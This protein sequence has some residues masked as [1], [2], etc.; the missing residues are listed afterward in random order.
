MERNP[1]L[2]FSLLRLHLISLIQQSHQTNDILPALSFASTH[3]APRAHLDRSYLEELERTMA[4]LCFP[5]DQDV[6]GYLNEPNLK[7]SVAIRVNLALIK[8][9]FGAG[10][11]DSLED[12]EAKVRGL[13]RLW[14]WAEDKLSR[15]NIYAPV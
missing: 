15:I 12:Q 8:G 9:V 10:Q 1:A 2:H 4:L 13:S 3:L 11:E 6:P 14:K 7:H 5:L